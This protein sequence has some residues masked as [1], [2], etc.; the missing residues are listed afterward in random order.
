MAGVDLIK[1]NYARLMHFP[2]FPIA[3]GAVDIALI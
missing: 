3:L 2:K 1:L